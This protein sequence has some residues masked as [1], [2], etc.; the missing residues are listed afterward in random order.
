MREKHIVLSFKFQRTK[1]AIYQYQPNSQ[2]AQNGKKY[3]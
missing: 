2:N 3:S 1:L